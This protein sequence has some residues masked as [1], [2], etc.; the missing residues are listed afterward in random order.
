VVGGGEKGVKRDEILR[1]AW[2]DEEAVSVRWDGLLRE[3][4]NV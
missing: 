3:P 4:F 1:E 2:R